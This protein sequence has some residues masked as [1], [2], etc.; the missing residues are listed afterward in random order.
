LAA[1]NQSRT[2]RLSSIKKNFERNLEEIKE[3]E[4]D[5]VEDDMQFQN[6]GGDLEL[7]LDTF[8]VGAL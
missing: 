5:H 1:S 6:S 8:N 7:E 3:E 2:V 4:H